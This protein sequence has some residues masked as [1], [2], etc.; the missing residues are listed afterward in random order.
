M[1][2]QP[3]EAGPSHMSPFFSGKPKKDPARQ[4]LRDQEDR[5]GEIENWNLLYVALTR[6]KESVYISGSANKGSNP[7]SANSWYGR[8]TRA[9]LAELDLT[10]LNLDAVQLLKQS[11]LEQQSFEVAD[12]VVTWHGQV[13]SKTYYD[14]EIIAPEKQFM[15]DL[16]IAFHAVMEHVVRLNISDVLAIPS[17]SELQAWLSIP[18]D[19]VRQARSCAFNVLSSK[20]ASPFFFGEDI[21]NSWEELD[22]GTKDGSLLR[23]DRLVEFTDKLV[24][25]DYKL[26]IPST[27]EV[28]Y[29]KYRTQMSVYREAVKLLRSDKPIQS[30]LLAANGEVLELN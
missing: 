1:N 9:G 5:I 27:D 30:Y 17:E 13:S 4:F 18:A 19:L 15:I 10:E 22:I 16:G 2:W 12:F 23:I 25:L 26:A 24:I 7:I 21:Q 29:E 3:N 11:P 20:Y 28:F 6:A 14:E 8:L